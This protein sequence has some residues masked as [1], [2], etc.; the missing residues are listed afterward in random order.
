[1]KLILTV[2][3]TMFITA[4]AMA[5]GAAPTP[6]FDFPEESGWAVVMTERAC[7]MKFSEG[8]TGKIVDLEKGVEYQVYNSNNQLVAAAQASST[9]IF[10]S[11]KCL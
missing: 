3:S 9:W 5:F 11:R 1:M 6:N 10:A 8:H 4:N 7:D 2:L